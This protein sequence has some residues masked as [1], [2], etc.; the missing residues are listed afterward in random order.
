MKIAIIGT[1]GIPNHYGGFEQFAEHISVFLSKKGHEITV[2][3]SHN[4]PFQKNIWKG[5]NI[6]HCYDPEFFLGTIGQFF[7]DFNCI[8]N[9]RKKNFDI[10]LQLGYTS[11]SIFNF[12][13]KEN[14]IIVTNMDGLE[15]RRSKFNKITKLFLRF[16]ESLAV[17]KSDY[18]ISDSI[19]IKNYIKN[20]YN[21]KSKYIAYGTE[22]LDKNRLGSLVSFN[23]KKYNY[24]LIV[25]RM[26]PENNI[27][28]IIKGFL[29]SNMNRYLVIVG[30]LKTNFAKYL[31]KNYKNEKIKYLGFVSETHNL[32][33]LRYYSNIYF[34]GHSVG[35][36]NPSLLEA[37]SSN[38]LIC[39][40]KN[41]FNETIL[42]KDGFYFHNTKDVTDI[43]NKI[44]K[45]EYLK[46]IRNN[47]IKTKKYY[48]WDKIC[49]K[50]ELFF[51]EIHNKL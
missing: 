35:G 8:L 13:F 28:M 39:A 49:T 4:H 42:D 6:I 45:K 10:I 1:R 22:E 33:A 5:V 19:G 14:T 50:Y 40:H 38:S 9:T 48:S 47:I 46:L 36:T 44:Q 17:K 15:W 26:E 24:D 11:S 18:L 23:L 21:I 41:I 16:S 43:I 20:K 27:E 2:Y 25:A 31:V 37:M 32:N 12:F 34:H 29:N 51:K 30:S 7:Y 3:N